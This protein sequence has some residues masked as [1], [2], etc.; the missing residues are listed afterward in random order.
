[1][2][3]VDTRGTDGLLW[4]VVIIRFHHVHHHHRP[5]T[6]GQVELRAY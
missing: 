5:A 1:L 6:A 3:V 4:P 2:T